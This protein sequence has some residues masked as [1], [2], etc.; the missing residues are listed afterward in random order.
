MSNVVLNNIDQDS[1]QVDF[2]QHGKNHTETTLKDELLDGE[3]S[4]HFA[5]TH[6]GVPMRHVPIHPI[7]VDTVL[8]RVRRRVTGVGIDTPQDAPYLPPAISTMVVSP[9]RPMYSVTE[10]VQALQ[11]F[12]ENLNQHL[13]TDGLL[14]TNFALLAAAAVPPGVIVNEG[15]VLRY[16]DINVS[17][18][19]SLLF[20]PGENFFQYFVI[21]FTGYG[22]NLLGLNIANLHKNANPILG[23]PLDQ[24]FLAPTNNLYA[25]AP[26]DAG[27]AWVAS[28]NPDDSNPVFTGHNPVFSTAD[29]RIKVS[30]SS[31]LPMLSNVL[32][33]NEKQSSERDIC[34]AFFETD[35][36]SE[37]LYTNNVF[38]TKI[39]ATMF[40]GQ[41]AMIRKHDPH[42]QWNKLLSSYRLR[43]MRFFLFVTYRDY[44]LAT[45]TFTLRK[46]PVTVAENDYWSFSIQFVSDT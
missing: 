6:L 23:V 17:C 26:F 42:H 34:E 7:A 35:V 16:L 27:G 15:D 24:Y 30:V 39:I 41:V 38:S 4:Y 8:F 19:S 3:K 22:A 31:H 43:Y 14:H 12:C 10:F 5:V 9:S 46:M 37:I 33:N 18:D 28:A 32:I 20:T 21:E 40:S 2:F 45:N 25:T 44:Q 11:Q 13:T 1:I 29:Q 36:T